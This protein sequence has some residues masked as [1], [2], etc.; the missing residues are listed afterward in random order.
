MFRRQR[1]SKLSAYWFFCVSWMMGVK[2]LEG[3]PLCFICEECFFSTAGVTKMSNLS[4]KKTI[5][6]PPFPVE[7]FNTFFFNTVLNIQLN[8]HCKQLEF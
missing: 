6:L 1:F 7:S 5:I 2:R 8:L 4:K 3:N